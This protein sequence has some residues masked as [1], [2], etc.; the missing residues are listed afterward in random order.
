MVRGAR[1]TQ[2]KQGVTCIIPAVNEEKT[3]GK[4]IEC[5]KQVPEVT[6]II[7]VDDGSTD[8]TA[9]VARKHK[10]KVAQHDHNLGK[11]AAMKTGARKARNNFLVYIDADLRNISPQIIRKL[12]KPLINN[13]HNQPI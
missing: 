2:K 4:V 12:I 1:T 5:V 8:E 10:V 7:V 9:A 13:K 11:G 3:I 6:E